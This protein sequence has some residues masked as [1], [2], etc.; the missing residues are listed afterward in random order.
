[1]PSS[2][3]SPVHEMMV[4]REV[5]IWPELSTETLLV[6][7]ALATTAVCVIGVLIKPDLLQKVM[8]SSLVEQLVKYSAR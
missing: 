3:K 8:K 4:I 1:M 2:A 7:T 5:S 6:G